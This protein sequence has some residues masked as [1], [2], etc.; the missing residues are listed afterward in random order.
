[1][2][3][4]YYQPV[5]YLS[6]RQTGLSYLRMLHASPDTPAVDVYANNEPIAKNLRY[7]GFTPYLGVPNG[8][9]TVTVYP[10]GQKTNPIID[11][12][13]GIAPSSIYT[14]STVGMQNDIELYS[15][16]DP[17]LLPLLDRTRVRF[18]HLSPNTPDI[19]ITLHDD[20]VLFPGSAYMDITNYKALPSKRYTLQA[21]LANT[22]NVVLNVPNVV[23]RPER[24]LSIYAVGLTEAQPSL[25]ILIPLD[26]S[27]YLP[28]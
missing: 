3:T 18:I 21:R 10:T 9:Y 16:P 15:I 7:K 20:T 12:N 14:A 8:L 28:L 6:T 26:G 13:M 1:M 17:A 22:D 11:T 2:H 24:N 27:S 4:P 5:D 23:L 25:Q 19:D